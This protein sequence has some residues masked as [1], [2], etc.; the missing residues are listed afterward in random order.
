MNGTEFPAQIR[1]RLAAAA[2]D[3]SARREIA[4]EVGTRLGEELL[5]AGAPGLHLYT[6][7]FSGPVLAICEQLGMFHVNPVP[8][9][10]T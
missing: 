6:M 7:N 5:A 2:D 8:D 1:A 3:V 4:V 10:E 9:A